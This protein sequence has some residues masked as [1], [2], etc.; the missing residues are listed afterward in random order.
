M[1]K[2]YSSS[3]LAK[4]SITIG[5]QIPWVKR[6][7]HHPSKSS[8]ELP[9][10]SVAIGSRRMYISHHVLFHKKKTK[11]NMFTLFNKT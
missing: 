6:R 11:V 8:E 7:I 1:E 9:F 10:I 4:Y 3:D 5:A 2:A